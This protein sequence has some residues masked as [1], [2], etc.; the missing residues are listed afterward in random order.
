MTDSLQ[1]KVAEALGWTD[2]HERSELYGDTLGGD[3]LS[4]FRIPAY[5][6]DLNAAWPLLTMMKDLPPVILPGQM[7]SGRGVLPRDSQA[8]AKII[9]EWFLKAK[10]I[11]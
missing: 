2:I 10:G 7:I 4:A 5:D 9:C 8:A 3:H 1:R 6:T 11:E